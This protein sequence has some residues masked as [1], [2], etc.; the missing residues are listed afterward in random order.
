[1]ISIVSNSVSE[2][3]LIAYKIAK[4]LKPNSII[5]FKGGLG[6]GKTSFVR[7]L[8]KGLEISETISSPTYSLINQYNGKI[9]LYHFDMYRILSLDDL[10]STG[11][12]DYLDTNSIIAIEWSENISS[13]LPSNT[14]YIEIEYTNQD[15]RILKITGDEIIENISY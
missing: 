14:I 5:A 1:M 3:E 10:Y 8:A 15:T 12:F 13:F 9:N 11:F 7:G 4:Y 6:V 2:T